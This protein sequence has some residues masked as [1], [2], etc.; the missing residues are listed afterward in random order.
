MNV[1]GNHQTT[2][3]DWARAVITHY[4]YDLTYKLDKETDTVHVFNGESEIA[5]YD[6]GHGNGGMV[7]TEVKKIT[8]IGRWESFQEINVESMLYMG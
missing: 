1:S 8:D 5:H 7:D 4:P 6:F 2:F 3:A